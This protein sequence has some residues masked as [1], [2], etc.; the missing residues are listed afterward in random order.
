[1]NDFENSQYHGPDRREPRLTCPAAPSVS[2]AQISLMIEEELERR[3]AKFEDKMLM[4]MDTKFAQ[5]HKIITD[6][7]PYGD[8]HGH[9]MAHE[10]MI[11]EADGWAKIKGEIVSK[12]LTGGLWLAAGWLAFVVWQAFKNEVTK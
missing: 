8:P 12:F 10:K 9:R 6:G 4:H 5:L 3:L 2:E 1:M 7:Y 11:R